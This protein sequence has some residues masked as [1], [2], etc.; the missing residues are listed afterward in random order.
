MYMCTIFV[1]WHMF[2]YSCVCMDYLSITLHYSTDVSTHRL[3][4]HPLSL[5]THPSYLIVQWPSM[6]CPSVVRWRPTE[7]PV[8]VWHL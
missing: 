7:E 5:S 8:R 6:G 2:A 3:Q 4:P 1:A